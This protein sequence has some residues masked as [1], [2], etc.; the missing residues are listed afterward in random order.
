MSAASR[1]NLFEKEE[2]NREKKPLRQTN[3]CIHLIHVDSEWSFV[4]ALCAATAKYNRYY[5]RI[6]RVELS[7]KCTDER[8]NPRSAD[9][10][11]FS[12]WFF[13]EYGHVDPR[14]L[15]KSIKNTWRK[16]ELSWNF[17]LSFGL[18]PPTRYA[19]CANTVYAQINHGTESTLHNDHENAW[20]SS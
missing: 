4:V 8:L 17:L 5:C 16:N 11:V 3:G 7:T 15:S 2:N 13:G 19:A 18:T 14:N 20:S 10:V 6:V 12:L 9:V 1:A